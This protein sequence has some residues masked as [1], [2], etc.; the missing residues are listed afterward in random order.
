MGIRRGVA[1]QYPWESS[2]CKERSL[3]FEIFHAFIPRYF[4]ENKS[5][6]QLK[7]QSFSPCGI[8]R[9]LFSPLLPLDDWLAALRI[10]VYARITAESRMDWEEF[11][12]LLYRTPGT[13]IFLSP[14]FT[15]PYFHVSP[16]SMHSMRNSQ[17]PERLAEPM[18]LSSRHKSTSIIVAR[19]YT[20]RG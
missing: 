17:L 6:R 16:S 14:Q 2:N 12:E 1:N 7:I 11:T 5:V 13:W 8:K 20:A 19:I 10:R 18:P 15:S 4:I 9:S 3:S